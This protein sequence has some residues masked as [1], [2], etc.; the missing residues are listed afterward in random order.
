MAISLRYDNETL[1]SDGD[2]AMVSLLLCMQ[3]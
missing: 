2:D 1:I 3:V